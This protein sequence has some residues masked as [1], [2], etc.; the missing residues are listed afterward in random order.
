MKKTNTRDPPATFKF[1][2]LTQKGERGGARGWP[3]EEKR[4]KEEKEKVSL[5][6]AETAGLIGREQGAQ[7]A[8][9]VIGPGSRGVERDA[10]WLAQRDRYRG[11]NGD[12]L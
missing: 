5:A 8:L 1:F 6:T 3:R 11:R 2:P 10:L 4:E 7:A 12:G 9:T